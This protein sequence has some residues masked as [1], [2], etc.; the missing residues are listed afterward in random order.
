MTPVIPLGFTRAELLA[1]IE[2]ELR[3]REHVFPRRIT[4]GKMSQA[5]ATLEVGRM[6]A[7]RAVLAQLPPDPEAQPSLFD[8]RARQAGER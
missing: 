2:R 8:A 7:V 4:E 6:R 1:C 3:Y 5:Q